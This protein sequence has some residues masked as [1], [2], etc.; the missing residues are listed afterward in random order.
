MGIFSR[1]GKRWRLWDLADLVLEIGV[2]TL[3]V[4]PLNFVGN[5]AKLV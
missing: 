1:F 4:S 5:V 3:Q 2:E